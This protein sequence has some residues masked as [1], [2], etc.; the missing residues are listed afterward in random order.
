MHT[1]SLA[2]KKSSGVGMRQGS[3]GGP[4][5]DQK[6]VIQNLK[7]MLVG[8][9][10]TSAPRYATGSVW[11]PLGFPTVPGVQTAFPKQKATC[12]SRP[13]LTLEGYTFTPYDPWNYYP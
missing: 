2:I 11:Y 13:F 5:I 4:L 9:G 7:D 1:D 12:W 3:G 8:L 10:W 6:D